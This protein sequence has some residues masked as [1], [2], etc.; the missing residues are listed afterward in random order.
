MG[1][2]PFDYDGIDGVVT[3]DGVE[4]TVEGL[5]IRVSL[6][7]GAPP[8]ASIGR[9]GPRGGWSAMSVGGGEAD[10]WRQSQILLAAR[11]LLHQLLPRWQAWMRANGYERE[12]E[13]DG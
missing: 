9:V 3:D 8:R 4:Q 7:N 6:N 2:V 12:D 1:F 11:Y 5:T 10:L 13:R